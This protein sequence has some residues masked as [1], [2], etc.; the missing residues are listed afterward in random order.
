VGRPP[1]RQG[2]LRGRLGRVRAA[3]TD[4]DA[5]CRGGEAIEHGSV[6]AASPGLR[7]PAVGVGRMQERCVALLDESLGD[8]GMHGVAPLVSGLVVEA[9][10]SVVRQAGAAIV[11]TR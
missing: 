1:I 3:D 8:G 6:A 2:L 10:D 4:A 7:R 11:R 9:M 5:R